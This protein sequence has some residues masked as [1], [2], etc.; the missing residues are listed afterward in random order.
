MSGMRS[1]DAE[2]LASYR[3]ARYVVRTGSSEFILRLDVPNPDLAALMRTHGATSACFVTAYNPYSQERTP[4]QNEAANSVLREWLEGQGWPIL[5]GAGCCD[6]DWDA[7]L[8]FLAFGPDAEDAKAMCVKF[9]QNAV[10]FAGA[11]AVPVL[12]FHP[13]VTFDEPGSA[14]D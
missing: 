10:L 14:H 4:A 12:L 11:D 6:D 9:N 8:S 13:E 1:I 5:E 3:T 7:E 2:T